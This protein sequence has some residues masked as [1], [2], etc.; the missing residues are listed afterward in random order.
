MTNY[1]KGL[2]TV[3]AIQFMTSAALAMSVHCEV[4][5]DFNGSE[6]KVLDQKLTIKQD[7]NE[8]EG[9]GT[10]EIYQEDNI[11][12]YYLTYPAEIIGQVLSLND[13][14]V[15]VIKNNLAQKAYLL[16]KYKGQAATLKTNFNKAQYTVKCS[17]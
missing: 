10:V 3:I 17:E 4:W 7:P 1:L 5:K 13:V 16:I 6:K 11:K 12:F 9:A 15:D 8:G 14:V 2:I